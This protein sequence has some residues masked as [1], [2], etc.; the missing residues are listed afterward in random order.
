MSNYRDQVEWVKSLQIKEGSRV[1]TDCPFCGGKNKFTLD[2]FDGKLIWNCYRASCGVKG[3]YS[4]KRD[5]NAAKSYLQGNATQRFKA[6]YKEIPTLTQ[7]ENKMVQLFDKF[8]KANSN[9]IP[10]ENEADS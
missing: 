3:A 8:S 4:G 2:K 10:L 7:L 5:I 1:T 6:K 9:I